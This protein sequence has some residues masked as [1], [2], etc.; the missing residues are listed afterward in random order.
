MY[1]DP[2]WF[3]IYDN[4]GYDRSY[5]LALDPAGFVYVAGYIFNNETNSNDLLIINRDLTTGGEIW[6]RKFGSTFDDKA[7]G[8]T[9]DEFNNIYITGYKS[10]KF[11]NKNLI[12]LKYGLS[13]NLIAQHE[14]NNSIY[15]GDDVGTDILVDRGFVYV[16][17]HTYQGERSL[18]DLI[19]LTYTND[20]LKITDTNIYRKYSTK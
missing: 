4:A 1:N 12:T 3:K 16:V 10:D 7:F 20:S 2:E 19:M 18:N 5:D 8:V 13:G 15:K 9:V 11:N 6:T 17:G 14:Y